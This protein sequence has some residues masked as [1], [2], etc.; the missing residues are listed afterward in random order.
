[1]NELKRVEKALLA[2]LRAYRTD[3]SLS[4]ERREA[5]VSKLLGELMTLRKEMDRLS[6]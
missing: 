3:D 2:E 4:Y 5:L 6:R 1:M